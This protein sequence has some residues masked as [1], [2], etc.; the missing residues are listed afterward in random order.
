MRRVLVATICATGVFAAPVSV[1]A[2]HGG[3][4]GHDFATGGGTNGFFQLGFSAQ[5]AADGSDPTGF[6]SA[7]SRPDG[8]FPVPFRFGGEVTCLAVDGNRASIK[9]R[10]DYADNPALVDGGIQIFVEDNGQPEDGQ[11]VD[12][13]GFL[14]PMTREAFEASQ[15]NVCVPP[16]AG[17]YTPSEEGDIVVHDAG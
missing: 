9:Y 8:G 12:Q 17:N 10:F 3:D 15:P 7:R 14:P 16:S 4:V 1:N 6:V 2:N 11:A 13:T 5:S